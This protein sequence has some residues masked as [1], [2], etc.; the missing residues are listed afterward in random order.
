ME[1]LTKLRQHYTRTLQALLRDARKIS[2]HE[3]NGIK[4]A[5]LELTSLAENTEATTK[6][7]EKLGVDTAIL[8]ENL[9]SLENWVALAEHSYG[10]PETSSKENLARQGTGTLRS[11]MGKTIQGRRKSFPIKE[12]ENHTAR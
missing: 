9:T 5:V 7:A 2:E 8:Q 3:V 4:Q 6:L 11:E 1:E 10:D 12:M